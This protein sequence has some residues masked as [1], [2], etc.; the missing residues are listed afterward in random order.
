[1][2]H[3]ITIYRH[4]LAGLTEVG[5]SPPQAVP[6]ERERLGAFLGLSPRLFR[7]F[8]FMQPLHKQ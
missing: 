2:A 4:P 5:F 7:P 1:M 6:F 3:H 8:L